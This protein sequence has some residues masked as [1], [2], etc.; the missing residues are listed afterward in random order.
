MNDPDPAGQANRI[1]EAIFAGHKIEAI[2][3]HRKQTGNGLRESKEAV[4]TLEAQLRASSPDSFSKVQ[5]KGCFS[6]IAVIGVLIIW[7]ALA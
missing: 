7:R 3:L 5:A 6:V 2:K 4:E 1:K